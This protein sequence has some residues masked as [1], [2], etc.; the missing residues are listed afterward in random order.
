ME[1]HP[2]LLMRDM[3]SHDGEIRS[4]HRKP[5]AEVI[6]QFQRAATLIRVPCSFEERRESKIVGPHEIPQS[7]TVRRWMDSDNFFEPMSADAS[8]EPA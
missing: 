1:Q 6:D 4:Y 5:M 7:D 2:V 3:L 8:F